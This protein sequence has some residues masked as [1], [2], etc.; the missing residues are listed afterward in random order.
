[1]LPQPIAIN[2]FMRLPY[3]TQPT[4]RPGGHSPFF[5]LNGEIDET[6]PNLPFSVPPI[7]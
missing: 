3:P 6:E 2:D 5:P 4:K 7:I 1:M